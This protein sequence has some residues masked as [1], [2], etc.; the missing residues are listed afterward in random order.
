[1]ALAPTPLPGPQPGTTIVAPDG[2]SH[3]YLAIVRGLVPGMSIVQK[4][5]KALDLDAADGFL[6]LWPG[7]KG[8]YLG[9]SAVAGEAVTVASASANDA[10]TVLSSGTLTGGSATTAVDTAA[11]FVTDTV[12]AG[13]C[14][15]N[16]TQS[17]HAIITSIAATTATFRRWRHGTTPAAGDTY[18]VVTPASTGAAVVRLQRLMDFTSGTLA[19]EYIVLNGATGV[20]TVGTDYFRCSRARVVHGASRSNGIGIITAT[21]KTTTAN[22]FFA[23]QVGY[24]S[25]MVCADTVPAGKTGYILDWGSGVVGNVNANVTSRLVAAPTGEPSQVQ[26]EISARTAG[27]STPL[28][29]YVA[30]KNGFA[31]WTDI[32]VEGSSDTNNTAAAGWFSMLLVDD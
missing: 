8:T 5:G 15:I 23:L 26:E 25:T 17:D 12:A 20:D 30:P 29:V 7:T 27:T 32:H 16:D 31:A 21:Q 1:M 18:R 19:T 3:D 2:V 11:D 24:G 28:R 14:I 6:A 4:F 9:F 13:D 10:G 22:I